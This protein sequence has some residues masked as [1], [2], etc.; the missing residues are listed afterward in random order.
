[1]V[2]ADGVA[3]AATGEE[4][5][6]Q[7]QAVQLTPSLQSAFSPRFWPSQEGDDGGGGGRLVFLSQQAAC[8]SGVH[9]G[10]TSVHSLQWPQVSN[11]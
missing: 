3:D 2:P 4:A 9:N 10:T 1:M 6:Q 5:Q 7:A 11:V 8:E